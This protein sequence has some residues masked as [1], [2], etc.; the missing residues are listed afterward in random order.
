MPKITTS[1]GPS[2]PEE[3]EHPGYDEPMTGIG[4]PADG[5]EAEISGDG[6]GEPGE[7]VMRLPDGEAAV[8]VAPV[9][10]PRTPPRRA[11]QGGG[12]GA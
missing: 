8:P 9:T 5:T 2:F 6:D 12:A 7:Q 4:H 10:A 1:T 3:R 11:P